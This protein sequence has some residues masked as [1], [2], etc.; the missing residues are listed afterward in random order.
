MRNMYASY[1]EQL[2]INDKVI[3]NLYIKIS[4]A[5]I[6]LVG[7]ISFMAFSPISEIIA[8]EFGFIEAS[9]DEIMSVLMTELL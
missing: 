5:W 1:K 4:I 7:I 3:R 9:L 8:Y 2:A 6:F